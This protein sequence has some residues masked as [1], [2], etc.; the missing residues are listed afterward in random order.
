MIPSPPTY[1]RAL[2]GTERA[3]L[4]PGLLAAL[5][6]G[7]V[8]IG[9][10]H[11]LSR[12]SQRVRGYALILVRGKR[13][14][15]PNLTADLSIDIGNLSVLAHELVHVWQYRNGMT[16][17]RYIWRDV[18]GHLGRYDYRLVPGRAYTAYGYEQ[19]AAMMEDWIRLRHGL[20]ARYARHG[21]TLADLAAV[22][23]FV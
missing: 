11:P 12:L 16:V 6:D 7:I 8:L 17:W 23:P 9:A 15:W 14:F 4:P 20:F 19:Q 13:I 1:Q 2:T 22:L 21:V 10:H 3:A 5:P 18:I